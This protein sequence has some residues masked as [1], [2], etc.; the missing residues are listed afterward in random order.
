M[1]LSL[2]SHWNKIYEAKASNE[3]TWAEEVPATSLEFIHA[4]QLP[5]NARMID[6][7]GGDSKLVDHLLREGYT[8][9]TVLDISEQSLQRARQRLGNHADRVTWINGD[10]REF[11]CEQPF[12]LW[13]DRAAFHF[14]TSEED[15]RSYLNIVRH[16]VRGYMILGTFSAA[17]PTQCSGLQV[18]QYSDVQLTEQFMESFKKIRC[19]NV[20]HV[21]PSR[22]IQNFTFC[23]FRK[24]A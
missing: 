21:T 14:L 5:K 24:A 13:H 15:I 20:D 18:K 11:R 8:D 23:S 7:G 10:I 6:V 3:L 12:D 1:D 19:V 17:G 16:C 4:F 2:K 22:A 9:L